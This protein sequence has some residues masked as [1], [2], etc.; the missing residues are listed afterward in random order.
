MR[1]ILAAILVLA[2]GVMIVTFQGQFS[3]FYTWYNG[4]SELRKA[5]RPVDQAAAQEFDRRIWQSH[6]R[7]QE[8]MMIRV[9]SGGLLL[10]AVVGFWV[11]RRGRHSP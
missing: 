5:Y 6:P 11:E 4:S 2:A 10:T 1:K 3:A 8:W 9:L 7:W